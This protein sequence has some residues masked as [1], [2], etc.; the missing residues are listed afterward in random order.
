[1]TWWEQAL[2]IFCVG[3]SGVF[4]TLWILVFAIRILGKCI[5]LFYE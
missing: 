3:F 2:R 1:M 4:I 5:S